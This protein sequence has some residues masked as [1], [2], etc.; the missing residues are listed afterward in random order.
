MPSFLSKVFGR[1]KDEKDHSDGK[2]EPSLLEGKF[3]AVS[4]TVSPTAAKF[5]EN[6]GTVRGKDK[7]KEKEKDKDKDFGFGLFKVKSGPSQPE[8]S[9][10][11]RAETPHLSLNLPNLKDESTSRPL[12]S[13]FEADPGASLLLSD[14][15]IG[16]R[17]LTPPDTLQLVR[18]CAQAISTRGGLDALG[19]MH[20]HWY[21]SSPDVQRRL[22]SL[23]IHSLASNSP[24]TT[25]PSSPVSVPSFGSEIESTRSPHDVT[26]VLRWGIR[27]MLLEQPGF[28][29]EKSWYQSFLDQERAAN[30]PPNAF[31]DKLL[32]LLPA[33]HVEILTATL[34][35][36]SSLAAH[37]QANG[38]SGSK[39]S[40]LIG[41]WILA[42]PRAEPSDDWSSFY[43]RWERAG[44]MFEHIF[45][46]RIRDEG[47][48]LRQ[49]TRLSELVQHYPYN[50]NNSSTDQELLPRPRLSTKS[51][52]TLFVRVATQ[53]AHPEKE[54]RLHP[55]ELIEQAFNA[56]PDSEAAGDSAEL[57]TKVKATVTSDAA[58]DGSAST[59]SLSLS[60]IFADDTIR[61]LAK[62]P[63]SGS[64][65]S[66]P[67]FNALISDPDSRQRSFSVG[68]AANGSAPVSDSQ[69]HPTV[70][71]SPKPTS[72][73]YTASPSS[74][75]A[76]P[77]DWSQFSTS[78]F[79]ENSNTTTFASTLGLLEKDAEV[80]APGQA[81]TKKGKGPSVGRGR[82]SLDRLPSPRAASPA[83]SKHAQVSKS[84]RAS[85]I[86][87]DEA[88]IDFWSD[89]LLDPIASDWPS[90]V[91]CKIKSSELA[92]SDKDTPIHWLVIEHVFVPVPAPL[93]PVPEDD[94]AAAKG[95]RP[96][97]PRPSFR[98]DVS[99]ALSATRRRFSLFSSSRSRQSTDG[100][101]SPTKGTRSKKKAVK[102]PQVG[103]MG[104]IL[105]EREEDEVEAKAAKETE[106]AKKDDAPIIR[107]P[108]PKPRKSVD[109]APKS[110]D[111]GKGAAIGAALVGTG[112]AVA[113][114]AAIASASVGEPAEEPPKPETS[115]PGAVEPE[116]DAAKE[117]DAPPATEAAPESSRL[118]VDAQDSAKPKALG[119]VPSEPTAVPVPAAEA[120]PEGPAPPAT[121]EP[122]TDAAVAVAS[123]TNVDA[124]VAEA[125]VADD[126]PESQTAAVA[127][128]TALDAVPEPVKE[129]IPESHEPVSIPVETSL[130]DPAQEPTSEPVH[131]GADAPVDETAAPETGPA[132]TIE[133]A[134]EPTT[135]LSPATVEAAAPEQTEP[136]PVPTVYAAPEVAKEAEPETTPVP[137]IEAAPEP[138]TEATPEPDQDAA[139]EPHA[140]APVASDESETVVEPSTETSEAAQEPTPEPEATP[141]PS[142]EAA[143]APSTVP[144]T[145]PEQAP[146]VEEPSKEESL[147][148]PEPNVPVTETLPPGPSQVADSN[149]GAVSTDLP[150]VPIIDAPPVVDHPPDSVEPLNTDEDKPHETHIP[151]SVEAMSDKP[152]PEHTGDEL[153][154]A[155]E[156]VVLSG[157]TPGPQIA[158]STS[159]PAAVE[160]ASLHSHEADA[161]AD[162]PAEK[163]PEP[164]EPITHAPVDEPA[165][166]TAEDKEVKEE[167]PPHPNGNGVV[168]STPAVADKNETSPAV[169]Q[170]APDAT[171]TPKEPIADKSDDIDPSTAPPKDADAEALPE[172]SSADKAEDTSEQATHEGNGVVKA[173]AAA[174]P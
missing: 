17:R 71:E 155:P 144:A 99:G 130:P 142:I 154:P 33:T 157:E 124:K 16:Q 43:A 141:V 107:V 50:K 72:P 115:V 57:W 162:E 117:S 13:L 4:P 1:K 40:K 166:E 121:E 116:G 28:G 148:E 38:T 125:A 161:A 123:E 6:A 68:E 60:Q 89:A 5:S 27:H 53:V 149:D 42:L 79:F 88:F 150:A 66:P 34:D 62:V 129:E 109:A 41:L 8:S 163:A 11:T 91:V 75:S 151:A 102:S 139:T 51:F 111:V 37:G 9:T 14:A 114:A 100:V 45:L 32:P 156:S 21:S 105:A 83:P 77:M 119:E 87:I 64:K 67:N 147:A 78:G 170:A 52:P 55:L 59:Q 49:P 86:R 153:P 169:E 126:T 137:G 29:L 63:F 23:F 39:L 135:E 46:A 65:S 165:G 122:A 138:A 30:Y 143:P 7:E 96:S 93:S 172:Q 159:E 76:A 128:A 80:T 113:G 58:A 127:P 164:A 24:S 84:S 3:E 97:S 25:L 101:T 110:P 22:I 47:I 167:E 19:I 134:P 174:E 92:L 10:Q 26:A 12:D 90:F 70:L 36:M 56:E 136:V 158:L 146:S 82:K 20:P 94:A 152:V 48:V 140:P 15:E 44:R 103:E 133:A 131:E 160:Q 54:A 118:P 108:S 95:R 73:V 35:L 18:A 173:A 120:Q 106:K 2:K 85:I 98:S 132:A 61:L 69:A 74:A 171:A 104:E 145:V 31:S 81:T 112:A 168:D